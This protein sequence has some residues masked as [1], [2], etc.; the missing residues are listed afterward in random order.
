MLLRPRRCSPPK[1]SAS[2][3]WIPHVSQKACHFRD[4]HLYL[5]HEIS[6]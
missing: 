5:T 3:R 4:Q 6:T 2:P 1:W